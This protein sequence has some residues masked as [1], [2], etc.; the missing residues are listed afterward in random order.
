L[1]DKIKPNDHIVYK[2]F[3]QCVDSFSTLKYGPKYAKEK[4]LSWVSPC[5]LNLTGGFELKCSNRIQ[6]PNA[7]P[8]VLAWQGPTKTP[9][10]KKILDK[11]KGDIY[12]C[13]LAF[14]FCVGDT[15][16]NGHRI[17]PNR[18]FY[19]L[20]D[21][22]RAA[23]ADPGLAGIMGSSPDALASRLGET[24]LDHDVLLSNFISK[25]KGGFRFKK[26]LPDFGEPKYYP[27]PGDDPFWVP[28]K[29]KK[30]AS[31]KTIHDPF[32]QKK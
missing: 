23:G 3:A 4:G 17:Y 7:P 6:D 25:Q 13:G 2:G 16:I 9:S 1:A 30:R 19:I 8:D 29:K 22:T 12:V 11:L 21:L 15:A 18:N 31:K 14:D 24:F 32:Y 26:Y 28:K 10:L 20:T 5:T 27:E